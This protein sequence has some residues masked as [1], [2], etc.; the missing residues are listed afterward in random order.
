V[1]GVPALRLFGARLAELVPLERLQQMRGDLVRAGLEGRLSPEELLGLRVLCVLSLV[2][3]GLMLTAPLGPVAVML[4]VLGVPFGY[5]LPSLM[6]SWLSRRR[7]EEIDRLLPGMAEV[8]AVSLEAGLGFDVAVTFICERIDNPVIAEFR[9]Y[10]ADMRGGGEPG[11]RARHGARAHAARPG[12]SA[13][14][15]AQ[16]LGGGARAAGAS[17]AH[18]P[19]RDLHHARV[20]HRHHQPRRHSADP[21]VH[22]EVG[23]MDTTT[24]LLTGVGAI[25]ALLVGISV[26]SAVSAAPPTREGNYVVVARQEIPELTLF[27]GQNVDQL[28]MMLAVPADAVPASALTQPSEAIG[29]TATN[30]LVP[31]EIVTTD[32]L[33]SP[34]GVGARAS[35]LIPP[36]K[37]ALAIT[38][39]E[40]VTVAGAIQPGDR[41]DVIVSWSGAGDDRPITQDLLQDVRVFGVGRSPVGQ[42]VG[43][44]LQAASGNAAATTITLLVDYQQA[45]LLQHVLTTGGNMALVLRRFDQF[46]NVPTQPITDAAAR[47]FLEGQRTTTSGR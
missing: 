24:K 15:R 43:V 19:D 12:C 40:R 30:R 11:R 29:K 5:L 39:N 17:A 25:L 14:R 45:V 21:A 33:A 6:L 18:V 32:R 37:V 36:D 23:V 10:L 46:G 3:L 41:V 44:V 27:T 4:S 47:Q 16:G 42:A 9:R 26:Y 28:L 22:R 20:V 2:A 38:A 34:E 31:R 7:R 35:A 1:S 8:L 13:A